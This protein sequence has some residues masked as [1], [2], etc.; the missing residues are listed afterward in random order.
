MTVNGEKKKNPWFFTL[1]RFRIPI[2]P[3]N[4]IPCPKIHRKQVSVQSSIIENFRQ[5]RH[6]LYWVQVEHPNVAFLGRKH[7]PVTISPPGWKILIRWLWSGD[8]SYCNFL[9]RIRF[10]S[11]V[12]HRKTPWGV[13]SAFLGRKPHFQ[14]WKNQFFAI[15]H[16]G[17]IPDHQF[18][19]GIG[20]YAQNYNRNHPQMGSSSKLVDFT[21]GAPK[22]RRSKKILPK[23]FFPLNFWWYFY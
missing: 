19:P 11:S 21:S 9:R 14:G 17:D 6:L 8:H 10:R 1:G 20:F 16:P 5:I 15:F 22:S 4:R 7:F 3:Q 12:A 13:K 18:N 23:P 2:W